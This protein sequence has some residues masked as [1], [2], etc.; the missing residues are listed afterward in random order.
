MP[1][2]KVHFNG[3]LANTNSSILKFPLDHGF[4]I[5]DKSQDEAIKFIM[6]VEKTSLKDA[7]K[8]AFSDYACVNTQEE[9]IYFV[10]NS[11]DIDVYNDSRYGQIT[12]ANDAVQKFNRKN[13]EDYLK[14]IISLMRLYKEGNV[15]MPLWYYFFYDNETPIHFVSQWTSAH[16]SRISTFKL[17][18]SDIKNLKSFIQTTKLPFNVKPLQLAFESF[19]L[20]HHMPTLSIPFLLLMMSMESLFNPAGQGELRFRISRNTAVLI[21]KNKRD[22]ESIWKNMKKLYDIRCE[23]VHKGE[24]NIVTE[25]DLL[26]LRNYVRRSVK[27]F[28]N[29]GKGKDDILDILNSTGFGDKPWHNKNKEDKNVE[30]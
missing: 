23:L 20:S 11:F 30:N 16:V 29:I 14:P 8:K 9:K 21:G 13:I 3:L 2:R 15:C 22:S 19:E 4:K 18:D 28:Y 6:T 17:K 25:K 12:I 26:L 1:K 27:E 5:E 10:S 7:V 24:S